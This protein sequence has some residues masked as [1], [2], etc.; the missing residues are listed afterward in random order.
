[1]SDEPSPIHPALLADSDFASFHASFDSAFLHAGELIERFEQTAQSA[2]LIANIPGGAASAMELMRAAGSSDGV[3]FSHEI[4]AIFREL[5]VPYAA[6]PSIIDPM[7]ERLGLEPAERAAAARALQERALARFPPRLANALR[8][9]FEQ[10]ELLLS[11]AQAPEA[12]C[13][14]PRAL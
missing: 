14:R 8:A 4:S 6:C 1:M 9:H 7:G 10:A 2:Q 11:Q 3:G 12:P 13:R 5:I